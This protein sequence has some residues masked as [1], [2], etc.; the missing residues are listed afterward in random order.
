MIIGN[1][2]VSCNV[3]DKGSLIISTAFSAIAA[4]TDLSI[5]VRMMNPF[6]KFVCERNSENVFKISLRN[7][8]ANTALAKTNPLLDIHNCVDIEKQRFYI[9]QKGL[10][11]VGPGLVYPYEVSLER[12]AHGL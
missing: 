9:Y 3:D 12:P 5:R 7:P 11:N 10:N 6:K 1:E 2:A 4:M 8:S